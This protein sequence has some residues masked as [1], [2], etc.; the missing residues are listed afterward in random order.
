MVLKEI[1]D[2]TT[3]LLLQKLANDI[4]LD[5]PKPILRFL[6]NRVPRDFRS[7]HETVNAINQVS[8]AKKQ[9]V[10]IQLVKTALNLN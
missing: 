7:L 10:T 6:L 5:L 4:K 3:E 1:D 2:N 8:Y 9:K